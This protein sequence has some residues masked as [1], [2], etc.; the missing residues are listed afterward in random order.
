MYHV[1]FYCFQD[2]KFRA[3][4]QSLCGFV[5]FLDS[6]RR[7]ND[8]Y[9]ENN[10][11]EKNANLISKFGT[12]TCVDREFRKCKIF[13]FCKSE[14]CG[15]YVNFSVCNCSSSFSK[16]Y[17]KLLFCNCLCWDESTLQISS[18]NVISELTVTTQV[19]QAGSLQRGNRAEAV[20]VLWKTG[21]SV[22]ATHL[23]I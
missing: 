13:E 9:Q 3:I 19:T 18:D 15:I 4:L 16:S 11:G 23:Q 7:L 8:N 12:R 21:F 14:T 2:F 6:R 10:I 17:Q 1:K 22:R 20:T 5:T